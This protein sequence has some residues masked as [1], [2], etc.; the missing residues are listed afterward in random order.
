MNKVLIIAAHTDDEILGCGGLL[1]N[2]RDQAEFKVVFV[3]E[4]TTCRYDKPSCQEA[5]K[6]IEL[7]NGFAVK[8]LNSLG[9]THYCFYNLPCGRL[10]NTPQIEIN[11]IIEKEIKLFSPDTVFT[12]SNCDSNKDHHK[13]YD[14]TIIA[15]RPQSLVKRVLSYEVLSSTEWGFDKAFSPNLFLSAIPQGGIWHIVCCS[16]SLQDACTYYLLFLFMFFARFFRG[17]FLFFRLL[18]LFTISPFFFLTFF[19]FFIP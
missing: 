18:F 3:A 5:Q 17:F 15:T 12:H 9:V 7:R 8:A 14:A 16:E 6:E 2:L 11:K 4:G 19:F 10:D 1:S 13:V